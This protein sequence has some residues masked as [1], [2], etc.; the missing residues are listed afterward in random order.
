MLEKVM[1]IMIFTLFVFGM[2]GFAVTGVI[3]AYEKICEIR[4]YYRE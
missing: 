2:I 1:A 3:F 4:D